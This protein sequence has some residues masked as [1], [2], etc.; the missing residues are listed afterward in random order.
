M[1]VNAIYSQHAWEYNRVNNEGQ[2]YEMIDIFT[3]DFMSE[4]AISISH[5]LK[6]NYRLIVF[7]VFSFLGNTTYQRVTFGMKNGVESDIFHFDMERFRNEDALSVELFPFGSDKDFVSSLK[8]GS[9]IAIQVNG[10][11][12]NFTLKGSKAALL[13]IGL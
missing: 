1:L 6:G 12:H 7:N 2:K 11:G 9:V 10:K 13:K 4:A 3:S 5:D 8:S